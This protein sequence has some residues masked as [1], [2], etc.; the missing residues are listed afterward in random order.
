MDIF[1]NYQLGITIPM[2]HDKYS[3]SPGGGVPLDVITSGKERV[4]SNSSCLGDD[5]SQK[6]NSQHDRDLERS[7]LILA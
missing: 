2:L 4:L 5:G 3:M 1:I 7:V 6:N